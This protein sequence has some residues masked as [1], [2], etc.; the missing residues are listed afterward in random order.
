MRSKYIKLYAKFVVSGKRPVGFSD[1]EKLD[2]IERDLG[3]LS[4]K[5]RQKI[6]DV[7]QMLTFMGYS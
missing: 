5:E 2:E 4:G 6:V 7:D 3:G 1:W